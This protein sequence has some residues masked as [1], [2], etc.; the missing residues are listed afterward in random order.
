MNW[1][2]FFFGGNAVQN[3]VSE[4]FG[5]TVSVLIANQIVKHRKRK[6]NLPLKQ[7]AYS[8]TSLSVC[9]C[10]PNWRKCFAPAWLKSLA[11]DCGI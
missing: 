3:Y 2:N 11:N 7:M 1:N 9:R 5:I 6:R 8:P 4:I 10:S